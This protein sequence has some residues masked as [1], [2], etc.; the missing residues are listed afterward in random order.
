MCTCTFQ[1]KTKTPKRDKIFG[2]KRRVLYIK[3]GVFILGLKVVHEKLFCPNKLKF[4]SFRSRMFGNSGRM[5]FSTHDN[6][7]VPVVNIFCCYGTSKF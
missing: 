3:G 5:G 4:T 6:N 1:P 7:V 2:L